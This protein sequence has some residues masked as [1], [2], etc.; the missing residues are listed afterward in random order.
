M[1]GSSV[2]VRRQVAGEAVAL[3]ASVARAGGYVRGTASRASSSV[4]P[5]VAA[6]LTG[7]AGEAVAVVTRTAF[8]G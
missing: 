3:V 4:V 2:G 1:A 8:A 6:R 7:R 5:M